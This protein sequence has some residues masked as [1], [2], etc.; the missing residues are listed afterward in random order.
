MKR[1]ETRSHGFSVLE[2]MVAL[3]IVAMVFTVAFRG[4]SISLNTLVRIQQLDRRLEYARSK[5]AELDLCGP[6]RAGDHAEG[7]FEDGT[8]W[9][10]DTASFIPPTEANLTS[11]MRVTLSLQWQGRDGPQH[12]EITTYRYVLIPANQLVRSLEDQLRELR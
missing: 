7:A 3:T 10:M 2:V 6:I 4:I 9:K 1:N 11:V 8:R 5:L 12:R